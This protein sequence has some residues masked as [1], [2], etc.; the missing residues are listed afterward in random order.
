MLWL[1]LLCGARRC[2]AD[3]AVPL[4]FTMLQWTHVSKGSSTFWGNA[5]LDGQL[6]HLLEGLKVTQVL[7]LEPPDV[8]TK[9]QQ[10]VITYLEN[11]G[12]L[13]LLFSRERP[14]NY[15][16]NLRCHLGCHLFPN[17]TAHS[18]YEVAL[19][20]TAFL[21]FHVPNATWERR[22][23]GR[24]EVAAF[25]ERELM[26]YTQTTQGLQHFLNTTCVD[27]LR[28]QS[29]RTGKQSS[30]SP[31][32]LVFGLILGTFALLGMAVGIFLGTGRSC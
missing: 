8:W 27:I 1:L 26:K 6:S 7:P 10:D 20:G 22:W 24:H 4:T 31:A 2:G 5:S 16:Q 17:G 12:Q 25:A 28:A 3:Q 21:S 11:F 29:A 32:P 13:V 23:P 19:N 15:S 14:M 30:R 18:F 9:R